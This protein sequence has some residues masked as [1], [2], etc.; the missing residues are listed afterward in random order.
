[1]IQD[2]LT[3][4]AAVAAMALIAACASDGGSE[5][6]VSASDVSAEDANAPDV[7]PDAGPTWTPP[8]PSLWPDGPGFDASGVAFVDA[9]PAAFARISAWVTEVSGPVAERPG[10]SHRGGYGTGNGWTFALLGLADPLNTLHGLTTPTY[11]RGVRFFGDY[12]LK[13]RPEGAEAAADFE[14]EQAAWSLSAPVVLTRATLGELRLDTVD[15]APATDDAVLR[16]CFIRVLTVTNDGEADS[17]PV[18]LEVAPENKVTSPSEGLLVEDNTERVLLT[19]FTDAAGVVDGKRLTRG[20]PTLSAGASLELVLVHCGAAGTEPVALPAV[21]AGALLDSTA[22]A[23]QAWESELVQLDLPDARVADFVDGMKMSLRVQTTSGGASCP[24]SQYTRTWARDNIG[25]ALALLTLGAHDDVAAMMDYIYGATMLAGDFKNSY[26]ADLDL[27]EL[28]D[29]PDWD[30]LPPLSVPVA[31][32]TPSYMVWIYG[33]WEQHTGLTARAAERWG[34]LRRAMMAQGFGEQG[35]LP[36]TGD[37]TFRAAM[38]AAYGYDIDHP[39]HEDSWSAN[40]TLLWLGA[41][42]HYARLA[43]LLGADAD[44]DAEAAASKRELV[45]ATLHD[46]YLLDDGCLS[47]LQWREDGVVHPAPFEDVATKIYWARAHG[48]D[49]DFA[50][51]TLSCLLGR[52]GVAPGRLQSPLHKLT[53]QSVFLPVDGPIYTG[54]LPGYTLSALTRAGHPEAAD[55]FDVVDLALGTSGQLQEYQLGDD[56]SG[57]TIFYDPSGTLTDYTAKFRPW[58]GGIVVHAVLD[59]LLGWEPNA[60]AGS[61]ALRPHLPNDWPE[62]TAAGLRIGGDRVDVTLTRIEHGTRVT[63]T[64]HAASALTLSLR[65]D[66]SDAATSSLRVDGGDLPEAEVT[67]RDHFGQGSVA[68]SGLEIEAGGSVEVECLKPGADVSR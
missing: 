63:V 13:L 25:P 66:V 41:E 54:M 42:R 18:T 43:A 22:A 24:M 10:V 52:L 26:D 37:E 68:T 36:F 53:E 55:A 38:N 19:A 47:A 15:F 21:D 32:E 39:H 34:W 11:E 28:P 16:A 59:Y 12:S 31:A 30:A 27:S 23:Y 8:A 62:L 6:D 50:A 58:E 17:S 3:R 49:D 57:L 45:E 60:T 40:S 2:R 56:D 61:L 1:M 48:D 29:A 14:T 4:L 33:A 64:S 5:T 46:T 44:A 9:H 7:T 65:C 20:I 51:G 35:H 67:R